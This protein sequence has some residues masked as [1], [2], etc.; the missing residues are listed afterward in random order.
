MTEQQNALAAEREEIATRVARFKAT[1]AQRER[2]E[3]EW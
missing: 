2:E 1:Q 3:Y